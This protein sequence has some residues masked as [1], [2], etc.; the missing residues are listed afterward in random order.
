MFFIFILAI[1]EGFSSR[2]DTLLAD[3]RPKTLQKY[4]KNRKPTK[5]I[6]HFCTI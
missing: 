4:K 5:I 6:L 1:T 3:I 2:Q